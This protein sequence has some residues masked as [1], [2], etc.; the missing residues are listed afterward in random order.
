MPRLAPVT[1]ATRRSAMPRFLS[2]PHAR[3]QTRAAGGAR[4][5]EQSLGDVHQ[6][7]LD[8]VGV[9]EEDGV[10]AGHVLGVLARRVEDPSA[11]SLYVARWCVHL[12]SALCSR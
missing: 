5:A 11:P 8:A 1:K 9:G 7:Q 4:S 3:G 10:V 12:R 2:P 6:L